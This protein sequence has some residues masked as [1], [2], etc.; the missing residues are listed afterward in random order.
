[1]GLRNR[2]KSNHLVLI[3]F[4]QAAPLVGV[5]GIVVSY[6]M[7]EQAVFIVE[8]LN[9]FDLDRALRHQVV[10]GGYACQVCVD[11]SVM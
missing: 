3:V 10:P 8:M 5:G 4:A 11:R 2:V 6:Q 9:D 1:M 7:F